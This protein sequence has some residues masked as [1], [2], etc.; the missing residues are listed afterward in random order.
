MM[1][2]T[3]TEARRTLE[4]FARPVGLMRVAEAALVAGV[5]V[6][7]LNRR[8]RTGRLPAWGRPRRVCLDHVLQP[9][10]PSGAQK[11]A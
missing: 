11:V 10:M 8:I 5:S 6:E 3:V 4:R 1:P 9:F 2:T 7:T